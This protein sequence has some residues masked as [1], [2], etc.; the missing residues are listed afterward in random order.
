M[1]RNKQVAALP[2]RQGKT[3]VE[4]LLVTTRT[5]KRW[6][7]PKGW[8]MEGKADHQAAAQEAFEEAGVEGRPTPD[9]FGRY[10]YVK[11]SDSGKARHVT[12]S[13]YPMKVERE[14]NDW[15]EQHQR[16]RRWVSPLEAAAISGEAE[17][18]P[19]LKAFADWRPAETTAS[20]PEVK[21]PWSWLI[22]LFR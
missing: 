3:G 14:L 4:I 18:V 21:T 12:V 5:T 8:P 7:I 19:L 11:V 17:L 16:E 15:P 20:Q 22:D 10:G 6:V 9:V 13:V 1:A 2:W